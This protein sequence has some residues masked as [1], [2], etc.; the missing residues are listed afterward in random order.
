MSETTATISPEEQ[1]GNSLATLANF[2]TSLQNLKDLVTKLETG[3]LTLE[4]SLQAFKDASQLAIRCEQQLAAVD[5][6]VRII[7]ETMRSDTL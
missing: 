3:N 2:E 5:E 4:E 6:Q 7:T 1:S